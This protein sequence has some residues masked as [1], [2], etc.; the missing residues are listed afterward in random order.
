MATRSSGRVERGERVI[1]LVPRPLGALTSVAPCHVMDL[2][3]QPK[4]SIK[5]S[6]EY[7]M[8]DPN[9]TEIK[10]KEEGHVTPGAA[11]VS[12]LYDYLVL[13]RR[14]IEGKLNLLHCY[15]KALGICCW[16]IRVLLVPCSVPDDSIRRRVLHECHFNHTH[17]LQPKTGPW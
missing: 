12:P 9:S 1:I 11:T 2:Y 17:S 13:H 3:R 10:P 14:H 16:R 7:A 8:S 15:S 6:A 4:P 5:A